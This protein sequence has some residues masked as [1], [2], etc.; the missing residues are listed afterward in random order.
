MNRQIAEKNYQ[1]L[2]DTYDTQ[3]DIRVLDELVDV[4]RNVPP[5]F[6]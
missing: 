2:N 1:F 4:H 5:F 6:L 3:K